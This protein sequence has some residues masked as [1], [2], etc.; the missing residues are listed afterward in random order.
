[1]DGK[2][3]FPVNFSLGFGSGVMSDGL[4]VL[5]GEGCRIISGAETVIGA[6]SSSPSVESAYAR[7]PKLDS[8]RDGERGEAAAEGG[9]GAGGVIS[10]LGCLSLNLSK[11][12]SRTEEGVVGVTGSWGNGDFRGSGVGA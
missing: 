4:M 1:M 7:P 2:R 8:E 11:H 9:S 6:S 10:T 3:T 5:A 12:G